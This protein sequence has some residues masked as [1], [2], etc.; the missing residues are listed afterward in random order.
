M[1]TVI[2]PPRRQRALA[3][4]T[5]L[6]L[7][8]AVLAVLI[9]LSNIPLTDAAS[10]W[11][12]ALFLMLALPGHFI[13]FGTLVALPAYLLGR[14]VRNP[15][16]MIVVAVT[17]QTLWIC[18]LLADAKVFA[19]YRFHLNA[20]VVNMIFG[21]ALQDQ[22]TFS[23]KMWALLAFG[24]AA[25]LTLQ[26]V[27]ARLWWKALR[28]KPSLLRIRLAWWIAGALFLI[29]QA[30]VAYSDARGDRAVMSQ[31]TYIPWAQPITLKNALHRFGVQTAKAVELPDTGDR[32]GYP[33]RAPQCAATPGLNVLVILVESLR[34]DV[35]DPAVM[36]NT[37]RYAQDAQ[38]FQNHFSTG[39]AT[40]FGLFG[41]MY[42]LPGGY[43]QSM[44]AEQRGPVL[45]D[46][47]KADGYA[48]HIYGSAP[49]YSPEFDRT[50]FSQ[51]RDRIVNGP[52][53]LKSAERDR[54]VVS[55]MQADIRNHPAGKPFFGFVFLDSPHAPYHLPNGY[56]ARFEPMAQEVNFLNLG[57][58]HDPTPELNRY[59]TAVHY[60]DEL[61]GELLETLADS[62]LAA[63]TVVLITGDHGEEFND[64][65]KNYWGH[66]GNFSDY[67]LRTPFV[68]HWPGRPARRVDTLTSH[69]DFVPT[70]M[71]HA[72]GCSSD[73][74]DYSTGLDLFGEIPAK[75]PLL[76]ES[77]S[78]RGIRDGALIYLFDNFGSASVVDR[79][80]EPIEDAQV[81]A[82]AVS[83][84]W[85]M[86]TRFKKR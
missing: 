76:V 31:L 44:L 33:R 20:M 2:I 69:E 64:L 37:W 74:A 16:W 86:L 60:S 42:G 81:S 40:R 61:I 84:S 38:W 82:D 70:V 3:W 8:N 41:L 10:R 52:S 22:V 51:V 73:S 80:Y 65:H 29:S 63:N 54:N 32:L 79:H 72:L 26:V 7:G 57:P 53:N 83:E 21:G 35:L 1:D 36:P 49:L 23:A 71:R 55:R 9:T 11:H 46:R 19:L 14:F 66:N 59:R 78:Q 56:R 45:I 15:R 4:L 17:L 28:R 43:W 48:M 68:L 6:I 12:S 77:W 25:L 50:V 85:E 5:G 75:R 39:N 47:M 13:F 62:P 67:Q 27:A 30:M 58:D 24:G 18:L 34:H